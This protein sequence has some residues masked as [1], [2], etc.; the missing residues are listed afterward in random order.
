[1]PHSTDSSNNDSDTDGTK[2]ISD[3]SDISEPESD[4]DDE[5]DNLKDQ[6]VKCEPHPNA[7]V[8][9]D[10]DD[11]K[12]KPIDITTEGITQEQYDEAE[13]IHDCDLVE[14]IEG[15]TCCGACGRYY[16]KN[17]IID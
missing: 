14:T 13:T 6:C 16:L 5:S 10:D 17:M 9:D 2:T 11:T 1:M 8:S 4:N 3:V 7:S 12:D 15:L